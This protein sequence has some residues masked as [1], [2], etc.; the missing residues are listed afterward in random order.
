MI[1][2]IKILFLK[3]SANLFHHNLQIINAIKKGSEI[4]YC[5]FKNYPLT[6]C[7]SFK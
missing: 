6:Y 4:L 7:Y 3:R 2:D 1:F 5:F